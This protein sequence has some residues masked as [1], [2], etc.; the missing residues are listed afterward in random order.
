[1][2]RKEHEIGLEQVA[3]LMREADLKDVTQGGK[4]ITT[5]PAKTA[6]ASP[7]LVAPLPRSRT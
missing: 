7:N 3:R 5:K 1:M 4:P 2:R 6:I